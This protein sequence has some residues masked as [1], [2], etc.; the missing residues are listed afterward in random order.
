MSLPRNI[1]TTTPEN[2]E[3]PLSDARSWVTPNRLF[4]V[5]NH[6]DIPE[7]DISAWRLVVKGAVQC[8]VELDWDQLNVLPQR[9]VFATMECAGNGRSFL[10]P[11]VEG[12]Q[13]RAGAV[14]YAEWTEFPCGMYSKKRS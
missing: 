9:S 11:K 2:R 7:I 10:Q 5:R 1:L 6:F 13:W 14:G 3:T 8:K 12:V 4:F